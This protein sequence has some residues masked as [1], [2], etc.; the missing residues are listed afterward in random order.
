LGKPPH[1]VPP[2]LKLPSRPVNT[3][4]DGV[5]KVPER[6]P[7]PEEA[8]HHHSEQEQASYWSMFV[9]DKT[10]SMFLGGIPPKNQT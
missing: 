3:E 1:S 8:S 4:T 9:C 10:Y 7:L 5:Q 6:P 2:L